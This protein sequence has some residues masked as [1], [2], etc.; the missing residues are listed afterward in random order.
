MDSY[1]IGYG[2][3]LLF[4]SPSGFFQLS[5]PVNMFASVFKHFFTF[6][7]TTGSSRF[8][9]FSCPGCGMDPFSKKSLG[10]AKRLGLQAKSWAWCVSWCCGVRLLDSPSG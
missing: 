4:N 2:P 8:E 6:L 3:L 5:F 1:F 7:N 9:F 10:F